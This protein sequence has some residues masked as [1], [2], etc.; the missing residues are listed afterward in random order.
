MRWLLWAVEHVLV[1]RPPER[2]GLRSNRVFG[3]EGGALSFGEIVELVLAQLAG[4]V[5]TRRL[6]TAA[7]TQTSAWADPS[8][9]THRFGPLAP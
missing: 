3:N 1:A 2:A 7:V 9:Y 5:H 8:I 6:P 4:A